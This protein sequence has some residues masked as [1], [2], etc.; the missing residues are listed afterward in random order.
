MN[1]TDDGIRIGSQAYNHESSSIEGN[2]HYSALIVEEN[3]G[4]SDSRETG[5]QLRQCSTN[6]IVAPDV[7]GRIDKD[8]LELVHE[9]PVIQPRGV[10]PARQNYDKLKT[11]PSEKVS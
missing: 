11:P 2:Q 9:E 6:T 5:C 8:S 7:S 1:S 4:V 3:V 10:S